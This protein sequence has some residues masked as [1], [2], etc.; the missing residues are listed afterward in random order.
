MSMQEVSYLPQEIV[1]NIFSRLSSRDLS[2]CSRVSKLWLQIAN[3]DKCW[4]Q[5]VSSNISNEINMKQIFI[6]QKKTVFISIFP[7]ELIIALG[8]T[9][10]I[11][12]FPY[13]CLREPRVV[14][15]GAIQLSEFNAPLTLGNF[16]GISKIAKM[17]GQTDTACYSFLAIR[18]IDREFD[19]KDQ[20]KHLNV[21]VT[22]NSESWTLITDGRDDD[23]VTWFP[24]QSGTGQDFSR[25]IEYIG[26]LVRG[27]PCGIRD[28]GSPIERSK[29]TIYGESTVSLA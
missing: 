5:F 2:I 24:P 18:F 14:E 9:N 29:L 7:K 23:W 17:Q 4:K 1:E 6:D 16:S 3:Q 13:I 28:V 12:E 22:V 26:R 8:G 19:P 15:N 27:E 11:K 25:T 21:W 20:D 10:K